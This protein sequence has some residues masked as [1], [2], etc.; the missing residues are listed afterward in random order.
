[1]DKEAK[2]GKVNIPLNKIATVVFTIFGIFLLIM[3][4]Y[5]GQQ[6][7]IEEVSK[8][9]KFPDAFKVGFIATCQKNGT[10][11][12]CE[13]AVGFY[14]KNYTYAEYLEVRDDDTVVAKMRE[15]C[16]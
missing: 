5:N 10:K 7:H 2:K 6:T 13:C 16:L 1:M 8:T 4:F 3:Y 11:E 14:E 12:Q 15:S 9:G